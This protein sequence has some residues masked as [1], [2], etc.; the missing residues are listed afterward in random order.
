MTT[1]NYWCLNDNCKEDK[2]LI[3]KDES[4]EDDIELCKECK[5]ELKCVGISTNITHVGTTEANNK[6]R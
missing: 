2:I 4:K 5:E 3:T 1:Y 6:R